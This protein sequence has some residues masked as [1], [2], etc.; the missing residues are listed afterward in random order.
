[1]EGSYIVATSAAT[2]PENSWNRSFTLGRTRF[3][4]PPPNE[5]RRFSRTFWKGNPREGFQSSSF[6]DART[7]VRKRE[8]TQA[9]VRG[10]PAPPRNR[11]CGKRRRKPAPSS[12]SLLN[13]FCE[14]RVCVC[15][16]FDARTLPLGEGFGL[17]VWGK[18]RGARRTQ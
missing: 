8:L 18:T 17:V 10:R 13:S 7:H 4:L 2:G 16:D 6:S 14:Q 3:S 15:G 9:R 12:S 1:M 5:R 11:L